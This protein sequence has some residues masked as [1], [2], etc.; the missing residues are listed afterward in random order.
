MGREIA[1]ARCTAGGE[2]TTAARREAIE[3]AGAVVLPRMGATETD[4]LSYAC[5]RPEAPD[6]MHFFQDRHALIQPGGGSVPTGLRDDALL[7]TS[8]LPS[9]PIVLLIVSMGDRADLERRRCGCPLEAHGWDLHISRVRSFEK[10]TAG[11]I[12]LLDADRPL[13]ERLDGRGGLPR[14]QLIVHPDVG[15]LDSTVIADVFLEA[16]G[17]GSEGER[18]MELQWRGAGVLEVVREPPRRTPS[19]KILHLHLDRDPPSRRTSSS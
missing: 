3:S 14:V 4:I 1:G 8:L 17:G 10:L 2:P 15:E 16:V 11:G 19:G 7:L 12:T 6:D 18:L 5:V 13:V 9:A